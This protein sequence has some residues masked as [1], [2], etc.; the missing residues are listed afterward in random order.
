MG[1]RS[2]EVPIV[3]LRGERVLTEAQQANTARSIA[4][5]ARLAAQAPNVSVTVNNTAG[6]VAQAD[7][8]ATPRRGGG[9]DIEVFV[10]E[11]ETRMGRNGLPGAR[12]RPGA[13]AALR[14]ESGRGSLAMT[15]VVWPSALPLPTLEGYGGGPEDQILR[16]EMEAGPARQRKRF[17]QVSHRYAVRFDFTGPQ[18][19]GVP[20][21]VRA[22][23]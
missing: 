2:G 18:F 5:M 23:G 8:R 19:A 12:R 4:E 17:T 11:I 10:E 22:Q 7:A 20:L 16:T 6:R 21:L 13:R 9:L 1:L 15:T 3:A 14:T